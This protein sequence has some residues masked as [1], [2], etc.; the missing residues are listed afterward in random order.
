MNLSV[1]EDLDTWQK[2][3]VWVP[4][5][6][7]KEE[8]KD[9]TR[10]TSKDTHEDE[11]PEPSWLATNTSH[12]EDTEGE[13]LGGGLSELITEVKEHDTLGSL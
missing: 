9:K 12:V 3:T 2:G 5:R 4:E 1:T 8:T 6:V 7:W 13:K 11:Q 10:G